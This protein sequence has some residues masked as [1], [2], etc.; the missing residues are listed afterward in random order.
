MNPL[1]IGCIAS[2]CSTTGGV[3]DEL[4][5]PVPDAGKWLD[6]GFG[7]HIEIFLFMALP[8]PHRSALTPLASLIP[9][10]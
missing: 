4:L 8:G 6:C 9:F 3:P 1:L 2:C 5:P 7:H 10:P